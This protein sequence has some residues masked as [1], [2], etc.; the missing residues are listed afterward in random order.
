MI[1]LNVKVNLIRGVSFYVLY[2]NVP[3]Q[4]QGCY[5]DNYSSNQSCNRF[6]SL[7]CG[8][9]FT[10][11]NATIKLEKEQLNRKIKGKKVHFLHF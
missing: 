4:F 6:S 8:K 7:S 3:H 2:H 5:S 1:L 11:I 9:M 10:L